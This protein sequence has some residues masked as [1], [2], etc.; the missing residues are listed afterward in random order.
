MLHVQSQHALRGCRHGNRSRWC[1]LCRG[2]SLDHCEATLRNNRPEQ[3]AGCWG[4]FRALFL[5]VPILTTH[6]AC[7]GI[8]GAQESLKLNAASVKGHTSTLPISESQ[9][10][11]SVQWLA[12]LALRES[13]RTY[14]GDKDWGETKK[15]WAGVKLRR[16]GLEIKT[17]RRFKELRHGRWIK[18]ELTLPPPVTPDSNQ[19]GGTTAKIHR[20]RRTGDLQPGVPPESQTNTHWQIDA[21]VRAPMEFNARI[22]RWNRG[23]QWY[24]I[25]IKGKMQVRLDTSASLQFFADY[26]EVPP[27][28]VIA[29]NITMAH[30]DLEE[31]EVDR[32]SKIG[33]DVAEEW[34]EIMEK[35]VRD[36][37]LRKQNEKLAR[38]L[39][40]SIAKHD[41]DL[42]LSLA[43]WFAKW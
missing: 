14:S 2:L 42:R 25:G 19:S 34:G 9:A 3:S 15:V 39:N 10:R 41:D 26:A 43:D 36:V 8:A 12:E 22:E 28:F 31:F 33:G 21:S 29:P 40:Q 17:K 13:P 7:S 38:K 11:A 35:V 5:L 4:L 23:V 32:V 20:V 6:I 24:S 30:L 16:E 1:L 37:F 18:Y 27:A